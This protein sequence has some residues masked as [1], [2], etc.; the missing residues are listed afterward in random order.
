MQ[1]EAGRLRRFG[2]PGAV[3]VIDLDH[4]KAVNDTMGHD[5]GDLHIRRS[6]EIIANTVRSGDIVARLGGDEFGVIATDLIPTDCQLL[7]DRITEAFQTAEIAVSIGNAAYTIIEGFDGAYEQAD[8]D[9][10]AN[11]S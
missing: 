11:A 1:L 6:A 4:V 9:S 7:V 8:A 3:I 10:A 5:A 2:D